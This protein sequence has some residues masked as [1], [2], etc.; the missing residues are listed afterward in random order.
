M[1]CQAQAARTPVT[2]GLTAARFRRSRAHRARPQVPE[3]TA[4][5]ASVQPT[6]STTRSPSGGIMGTPTTRLLKHALAALVLAGAAETAVA[7]SSYPSRPDHDRGRLCRGRPGG[8]A[9]QRRRHQAERAAEEPGRRRQQAGRQRHDR[10]PV[11]R[12]GRAR[13]AHAAV[14]D[15]RHDHDRAAAPRAEEGRRRPPSSSRSSTWPSAR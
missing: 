2:C 5:T 12:P 8:C 10:C 3:G 6:L 7:Q 15:R 14:R 9:R 4:G 13:R 1:A 11:G